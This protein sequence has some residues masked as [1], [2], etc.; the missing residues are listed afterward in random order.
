[1]GDDIRRFSLL[2]V[3]GYVEL[4]TMLEKLFSIDISGA[5]DIKYLDP[6]NDQITGTLN[7]KSKE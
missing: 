6:E 4:R 1:M 5:Y 3:P 7:G 2:K